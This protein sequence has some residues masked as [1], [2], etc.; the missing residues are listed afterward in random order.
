MA[1]RKSIM[2]VSE[3]PPTSPGL[4]RLL[5]EKNETAWAR[6]VERYVPLIDN[7][8]RQYGLQAADVDEVRSQ[9]LKGLVTALRTLRYDP[10]KQFCGYLR[11]AVKNAV[12][13]VLKERQLKPGNFGVGGEAVFPLADLA[14][15]ESLNELAATLDDSLNE[16]LRAVYR[17]VARVRASVTDVAWRAYELT[18]LE[19]KTASEAAAEL[20]KT[21]AAVYMA[22]SRVGKLLREAGSQWPLPAGDA[23]QG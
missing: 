17:T 23:A 6:F 20:G 15:P 16:D 1:L 3:S 22:K 19:G 14:E 11:K 13:K 8:S 4:L 2:P 18:A 12:W 10:A 9:V 5:S 7:W 21:V